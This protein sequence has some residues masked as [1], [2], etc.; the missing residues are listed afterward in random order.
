LIK[1]SIK[2]LFSA[3]LLV[4]IEVNEAFI[5]AMA[6]HQ[7]K[8][9]LIPAWQDIV[10]I[11]PSTPT[12]PDALR[13]LQSRHSGLADAVIIGITPEIPVLFVNKSWQDQAEKSIK[14][15]TH[16]SAHPP[17]GTAMNLQALAPRD[18]IETYLAFFHETGLYPAA[19]VK[20]YTELNA[21]LDQTC[22]AE[23][24]QLCMYAVV[25]KNRLSIPVFR[26]QVC[27]HFLT[28]SLPKSAETF[29]SEIR[30][31]LQNA[32]PELS[33]EQ[34]LQKTF[35]QVIKRPDADSVAVSGCEKMLQH[36]IHSWQESSFTEEF[37]LCAGAAAA[38]CSQ[39]SGF[40]DFLPEMD[41]QTARRQKEHSKVRKLLLR[42]AA[43]W[44]ILHAILLPIIFISAWQAE[45]TL[46]NFTLF[47]A[48]N[49]QLHQLQIKIS[50]TQRQIDQ[51]RALLS[52]HTECARDLAL[53]ARSIPGN[54]VLNRIQ[55]K[56]GEKSV[57][58]I[59]GESQEQTSIA[60]FL[61]RLES[62]VGRNAVQL[63]LLEEKSD[64]PQ[65]CQF[66]IKIIR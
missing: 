65:S 8:A 29:Q 66:E 38:Y 3:P 10:L 60:R 31:R 53:I 33:T 23:T 55:G 43:V 52:G 45:Q 2:N 39:G 37:L 12:L 5:R 26:G 20:G 16:I 15:N 34:D 59:K 7:K 28:L 62:N 50:E 40:Y 4:A 51:T 49:K 19:L 11:C 41:H 1:E 17:S 63:S 46:E 6:F 22:S 54:T 25:E 44:L 57:L 56:T 14:N 36:H 48:R 13:E 24:T 58:L 27:M 18:Q 35:S 64:S 30:N 42:S 9:A 32:I 61:E 47:T 21:I